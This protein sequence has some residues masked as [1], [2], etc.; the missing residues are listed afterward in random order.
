LTT[1]TG[2]RLAELK[3]SRSERDGVVNENTNLLTPST[4]A[5]GDPSLRREMSLVSNS[6]VASL[7]PMPPTKGSHVE[8]E[9][10]MNV[11]TALY[12]NGSIMGLSCST[13]YPA[14]SRPVD[15]SIPST[16]QPTAL[17][18]I[19]IHPPWID[20]FP[21]PEMRDNL[22]NA[23]GLVEEEDFLRDLFCMGS[24]EIKPGGAPWDPNAWIIG[25][26][27]REKWGFLFTEQFL[28]VS[29]KNSYVLTSC[30]ND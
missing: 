11:W 19:T 13:V 28:G 26:A 30:E 5:D 23:I 10:P 20:R 27:F 3:T 12:M 7:V 8:V 1:N 18:L 4:S 21:F 24:F 17:Q 15:P 9:L 2:K 22:I 14:K 6:P 16:L 29:N 25:E